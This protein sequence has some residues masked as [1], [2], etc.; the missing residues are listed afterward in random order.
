MAINADAHLLE[1]M[2]DGLLIRLESLASVVSQDL[3]AT[4]IGRVFWD[5]FYN[6]PKDLTKE[7]L[8]ADDEALRSQFMFYWHAQRLQARPLFATFMSDFGGNLSALIKQD[9]PH[10]LRDRLG[11]THWPSDLDAALPVALMCFTADEVRQARAESRKKGAVCS[12]ARPTVLDTEMSAAFVPAP[13]FEGGQSFGH[14]L[15]LAQSNVPPSF[16]PELLTFP[17]RYQARHLKALG[18]ISR[19]HALQQT[20]GGLDEAALLAARNRHVQGLQTLPDC[21]DFAEILA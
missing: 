5:R 19:P 21:A 8:S 7:K 18:F 9:W 3:M 1:E 10:L 2:D 16:T 20:D 6:Y 11:L 13:R 12:F 4:A 17:L 14:T 15:D